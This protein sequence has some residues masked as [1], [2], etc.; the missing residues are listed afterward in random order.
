MQC[1]CAPNT[2]SIRVEAW[3][4]RGVSNV[5]GA[6]IDERT[7]TGGQQHGRIITPARHKVVFIISGKRGLE[8][9]YNDR[10]HPR[11][12][13]AGVVNGSPRGCRQKGTGVLKLAFPTRPRLIGL[14]KTE[15]PL[16]PTTAQ[17]RMN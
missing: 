14:E 6:T 3:L 2:R 16:P 11:P 17:K 9:G 10:Q 13:E 15:R 12:N 5:V 8:Y 1:R 4:C 7:F